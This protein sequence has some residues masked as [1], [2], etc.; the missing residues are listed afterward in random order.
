LHVYLTQLY[1]RRMFEGQ[2]QMDRLNVRI[3]AALFHFI[4]CDLRYAEGG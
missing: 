4:V 1:F 3:D 2:G